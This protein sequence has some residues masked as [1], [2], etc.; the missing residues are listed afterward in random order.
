[1]VM[2]MLVRNS[3]ERFHVA[4]L[5]Q[6]QMKELNQ[7]IRYGIFDAVELFET[8]SASPEREDFYALQVSAIPDYWEVPGRDPRP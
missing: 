4:H 5:T 2:A 1:M 8:M 3:I 6:E 7:Q